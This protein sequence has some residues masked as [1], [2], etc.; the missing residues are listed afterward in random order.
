MR[1]YLVWFRRHWG[2]RISYKPPHIRLSSDF[3]WSPTK[4]NFWDLWATQLS[5]CRRNIT[6]Y[7][8][9]FCILSN[10]DEIFYRI[11]EETMRNR[12]F[13]VYFDENITEFNVL[14]L[15]EGKWF[16]KDLF[17]YSR[18][19]PYGNIK[20]FGAKTLFFVS[21]NIFYPSSWCRSIKKAGKDFFV[22]CLLIAGRKRLKNH[23]L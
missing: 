15:L 12:W 11:Q 20:P 5:Q 9:I 2:D 17:P 6:R 8:H 19:L 21:K 14:I 16:L 23:K 10:F 22:M 13:W 7:H 18:M 1:W 3:S 4:L